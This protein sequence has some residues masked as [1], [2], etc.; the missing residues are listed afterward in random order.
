MTTA[1]AC[2][3]GLGVFIRKG[4]V[5]FYIRGEICTRSSSFRSLIQGH[6]RN[7]NH[8]THNHCTRLRQV[9]QLQI[10]YSRACEEHKQL[11][12]PAPGRPASYPAARAAVPPPPAL[13]PVH[14]PAWCICLIHDSLDGL[15]ARRAWR[16]SGV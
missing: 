5:H 10:P 11:H 3:F 1:L 14:P 6:V 7:T 16:V 13:P 9:V 4:I 15:T 12:S 2:T 8:C